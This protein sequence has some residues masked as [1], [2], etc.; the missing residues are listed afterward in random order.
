MPMQEEAL[1]GGNVTTV[2]KVGA[3]VRRT[4]GPWTP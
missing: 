1:T 3:T 4:S 2:V